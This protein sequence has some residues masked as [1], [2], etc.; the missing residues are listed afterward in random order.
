MKLAVVAFPLLE[1]TDRQW[2]ESFRATHDPQ[3]AQIGVH[4]TLV[5]PVDT[6]RDA[7]DREI[8]IVATQS[9]RFRFAIQR[10]EVVP[11]HFGHGFHVFLVPNEGWK[12]IATLHNQLYAG[13]LQTYLRSDIPFVPHLTVGAVSDSAAALRLAKEIDSRASHV[14]G[15]VDAMELVDVGTTHIR[16]LATYNLRASNDVA[17]H[18]S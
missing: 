3:S 18:S 16:T 1:D 6:S 10:A 15:T 12:P 8:A 17:D 2:I 7:M 13:A 9:T 4:F 11:D 5:F 14:R